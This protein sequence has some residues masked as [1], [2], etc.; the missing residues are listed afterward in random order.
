VVHVWALPGAREILR[1]QHG[2]PVSRIAFR[3]GSN[4]IVT[5]SDDQHVRVIDI[6]RA[7]GLAD[8]KCPDKVVDASFSPDG[9]V[10]AALSSDGEVSLF[11]LVHRKLIRKLN[12][13]KPL[14]TSR[15]APMESAWR[16]PPVI[17]P[18]SGT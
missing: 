12:G 4:Q 8:F 10:L 9:N 1:V 18:S 17:S 15:S 6:T 11:D 3:P 7:A 16:H 13:G 14:S 5:A 2:A